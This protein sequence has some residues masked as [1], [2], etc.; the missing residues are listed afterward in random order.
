MRLIFWRCINLSSDKGK[1]SSSL[2]FVLASL[3]TAIL[4]VF[5]VFSIWAKEK[6]IRIPLREPVAFLAEKKRALKFYEVLSNG[7]DILNP[8]LY[9]ASMR[10][11][12]V[13]CINGVAD[14]NLSVLD[15][16]CGTG[17]TTVGIL[18][19]A[20]VGNVFCVDINPKQLVR[21]QRNLKTEKQR[22]SIF[23][24]D[25]ENLSFKDGKFDAVV[26]VGAIEYFPRPEKALN[27]MIRVLKPGG[28]V[29]IAGPESNWFRKLSLDRFFYTP[30]M[31]ELERMFRNNGLMNVKV[32]LIGLN[33]ILK[34]TKYVV[35]AVGTKN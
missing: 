21:A 35:V 34:T 32:L 23:L 9:T 28:R 27:E 24:G 25:V 22:T 14:E 4:S 31:V 7:Y 6:S 10:T 18:K 30:S 33:T 20:A 29:V 26:S 11:S 12:I 3:L 8:Y 19:N 2:L 1:A 15:V 17:Y 16:G 13:S 5:A